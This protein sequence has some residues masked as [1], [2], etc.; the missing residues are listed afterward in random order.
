MQTAPAQNTRKT[1]FSIIAV[2]SLAHFLNDTMQSIIN[3]VYPLLKENLALTFSQIGIIIFT[4]QISASI[5]QPLLGYVFDRKPAPYILPAGLIFTMSHGSW[6]VT[7]TQIPGSTHRGACM[8]AK[9][10]LQVILR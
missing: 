7:A 5:M 3:A 2:L 6:K 10:R 9:T 4:Y 1:A 8:S